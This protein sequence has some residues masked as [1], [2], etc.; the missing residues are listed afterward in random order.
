L[1][2]RG[3]GVTLVER[4]SLLSGTS[5]RHHGLL[6]S[7]ARYALHD[8]E[9]ARECYREN[10]IL[11]RLAPQA[12]EANDGLFVA[13]DA[14]D[15]AIQ[16]AFMGSCKAAG[17]PVRPLGPTQA[18]ALE[19][20]LPADIRG[21]VQV[22]DATMD[23]WRLPL[24]FFA[25]AH[26]R[27]ARIYPFNQVVALTRNQNRVTGVSVK[28]L[29]SD[30]QMDLTA[31]LVVNAA[32]PWAGGIAAMAGI[33]IP[34]RPA[35]GVM[36]SIAGRLTHMVINRLHPAGEGDI[37]VPQRNLTII[38]TTAWLAKNPEN[39]QTPQDHIQ[40]L[41]SLGSR[42]LPAVLDAPV[43]AAWTASRPL[44]DAPGNDD[45]MRMSRGFVCIDHEKSDGLEGLISMVGG[46]ATTLRAMAEE[47]ADLI[48]R[49]TGRSIGCTTATAP[50]LPYR[51]LLQ[52]L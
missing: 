29:R 34:L 24:H 10:Q 12:I 23:A 50:L 45:P 31:D 30:K 38:G 46:K 37:T 40:R 39:V 21:A 9:T 52:S 44:L 36:V 43:H 17:I 41:R 25:S 26:A 22:P 5:G 42:L 4:G 7:G 8:L 1:T 14:E 51:H 18:L 27:G 32:G 20:A 16:E 49:K 28:D 19:P 15:A 47:A 2:L 48:C 11:R 35:P 6:H 13:L 3:F 33:H